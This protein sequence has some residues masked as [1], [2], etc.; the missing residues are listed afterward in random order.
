MSPLGSVALALLAGGQGIDWWA[1]VGGF[2]SGIP[3][4]PFFRKK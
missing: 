1:H 3:L 2:I 4:V